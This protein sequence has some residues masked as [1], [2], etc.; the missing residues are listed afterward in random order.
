MRIPFQV[1][2]VPACFNLLLGRPWIHKTKAVPSSLHQKLK[3]PLG[4]STVTIRGDKM[5]ISEMPLSAPVLEIQPESA[6]L[7]L[8]GFTF[9]SV[10]LIEGEGGKEF[11]SLDFDPYAN[12]AVANMMKR[13]NYFPGLGLGRNQQGIAEFPINTTASPPAGLGYIPT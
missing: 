10:Q 12:T 3:F 6:Q 2:D 1:V 11:V 13:M 5:G 4:A 9:E 7:P 8:S